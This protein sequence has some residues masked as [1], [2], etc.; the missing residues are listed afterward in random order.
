MEIKM[1]QAELIRQIRK[2][3][4]KNYEKDGWDYLVECYSDQEII[5]QMGNAK[6]LLGAIRRLSWILKIKNEYRSECEAGAR[7]WGS[8]N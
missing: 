2:Y 8:F 7:F 6:T 3:G 1:K 5:E 4:E